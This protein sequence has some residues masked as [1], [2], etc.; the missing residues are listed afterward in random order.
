M[1][2]VRAMAHQASF[3]TS[4]AELIPQRPTLTGLKKAAL[5]CKACPL[6]KTGTQTVFGEGSRDARVLL[7][8]IGRAHV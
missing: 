2:T 6:W 4:A 5:G 7:I 3:L 8:E 1:L